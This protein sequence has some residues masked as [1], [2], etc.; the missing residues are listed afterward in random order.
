[1]YAYPYL[2]SGAKSPTPKVFK[3]N[4]STSFGSN[5][6]SGSSDW[7]EV[8]DVEM[9]N[10][11]FSSIKS[12]FQSYHTWAPKTMLKWN[13]TF[14]SARPEWSENKI[15]IH[16]RGG[17][18]YSYPGAGQIAT[19]PYITPVCVMDYNMKTTF[20]AVE[21]NSSLLP[22]RIDFTTEQHVSYLTTSEFEQDEIHDDLWA[23]P[24]KN[25]SS[26]D[27]VYNPLGV[28]DVDTS[29]L[30]GQYL[31]AKYSFNPTVKSKLFNFI[32]KLTP[33]SRLNNS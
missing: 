23:A 25:D 13:K 32:I 5:P 18:Q 10:I 27:P 12:G 9:F 28:N 30:F 20:D 21:L 6:L 3:L 4:V 15:Y 2:P 14:V 29:F 19:N 26:I 16:N 8:T 17:V 7:L 22:A 1:V 33:M 24:I 11:D 31:L